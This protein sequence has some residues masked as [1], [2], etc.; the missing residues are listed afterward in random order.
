MDTEDQALETELETEAEAAF[1]SKPDGSCDPAGEAG[2][3]MQRER[4]R[5]GI[6]LE[7]AGEACGVHPHHLAAIETGDMSNM[8]ERSES[9]AMIGAYAQYLGFEAEPLLQHFVDILPKPAVAPRENHPANPSWLSS[10]KVI[11]F[12]RPLR[13]P[14]FNLSAIPG[15]AGGLIASSLAAIM[16]FAGASWYLSPSETTAPA[17][18]QVAAAPEPTDATPVKETP[19]EEPQVG[20]FKIVETP[21]P[22]ENALP[23]IE[24]DVAQEEPGSGLEDLTKFIEQN[25]DGVAKPADT[26]TASTDLAPASQGGREF[27]GENSASRLVL[28]AK[29]PVWVRVEDTQGNVVMTQMLMAGDI[30]RVPQREDLIVIARDG[31][32]ISYQI[33]GKDRGL[34]G[35][36]GEILVGRPLTLKELDKKG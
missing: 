26:A 3:F 21:M 13:M 27:G 31:G 30:Y 25:V 32:L 1:R 4:E 11:K 16:I 24:T 7:A 22:D 2:W 23:Q 6:S 28:K 19:A 8:P 18:E 14:K 35:P 5:R 33:D 20:D 17:T 15:G 9:L 34:L 36:P 12:G 29:A 10:A